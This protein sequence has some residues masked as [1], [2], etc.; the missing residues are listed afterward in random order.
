MLCSALAAVISAMMSVTRRTLS[1]TSPMVLPACRTSRVPLLT[2]STESPIRALI[3][4]AAAAERCAKL[5]TSVATTA[6]PRPCSPARAASTAAFRARIFVWKAMPS[7]TPM[8]STI[9]VD[10]VSMAPMVSTTSL[11]MLPPRSATPDAATAI[12]LAWRA[13]SA[14]CFTVLVSSS[15][16][17]AV[18]S[19]ELACCS[20]RAD[21]SWLP[22]AISPDAVAI[23]LVPVCTS[24][25]TLRSASF[26]PCRARIRSPISSLAA[27]PK[28]VRKSPSAT[29]SATFTAACS[30]T[31][32]E[33]V[34]SQA[35]TL[36]SATSSAHRVS[37]RVKLR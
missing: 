8:M 25:T 2:C 15:I 36:P 37:S 11:T 26:M 16:D 10:A 4:R 30:G 7:M 14:F 18:S 35:Q 23:A 3:S 6:K 17:D 27:G 9:F 28:C 19:S 22:A 21:R 31:V 24:D 32:I 5:R 12:W 13:L 34:I 33:R 1:T 20:V 29:V